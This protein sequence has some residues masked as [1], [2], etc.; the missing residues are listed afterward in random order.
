VIARNPD[1]SPRDCETTPGFPGIYW[2]GSPPNPGSSAEGAWEEATVASAGL[3][4]QFKEDSTTTPASFFCDGTSWIV[5]SGRSDCDFRWK[6]TNPDQLNAI[7]ATWV[8]ML[9]T[10]GGFL[11]RYKE[12]VE[13]QGAIITYPG[14]DC[15]GT[16]NWWNIG[17]G[18]S[19]SF[20]DNTVTTVDRCE[21]WSNSGRIK[22]PPLQ[23]NT[24]ATGWI[25]GISN[26]PCQI[27]V[28]NTA[29]LEPFSNDGIL[30]QIPIVAPDSE[31]D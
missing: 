30:L 9:E 28:S 31:A 19:L 1:G 13:T 8:D 24:L 26:G 12:G 7:P 21:I 23:H 17:P 3:T 5:Q 6:L 27:N 16:T 25:S 15:L 18:A 20:P 11:A 2:A 14:T 29:T 22:A 10:H 4:A